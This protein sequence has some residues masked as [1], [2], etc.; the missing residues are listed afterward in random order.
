MLLRL[1]LLRLEYVLHGN[2][3][4]FVASSS[5]CCGVAKLLCCH[6]VAFDMA[7]MTNGIVSCGFVQLRR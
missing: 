4:R 3:A 5:Y 1:G 2:V 6:R 7:F